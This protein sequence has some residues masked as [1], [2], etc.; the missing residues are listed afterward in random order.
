MSQLGLD[1]LASLAEFRGNFV[2]MSNPRIHLGDTVSKIEGNHLKARGRI[3]QE[4]I[5]EMLQGTG[6]AIRM[7]EAFSRVRTKLWAPEDLAEYLNVPVGWI[8]KR[9]RKNGP[10][11][12]PHIKLGKYLRFDPGSSTFQGWLAR[13]RVGDL[14]N[15]AGDGEE[16]VDLTSAGSVNTVRAKEKTGQVQ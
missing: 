6:A 14:G 12:I 5:G 13:H 16:C 2:H 3:G 1:I 10:E 7:V 15:G 11:M 8:Y 4:S 9:T